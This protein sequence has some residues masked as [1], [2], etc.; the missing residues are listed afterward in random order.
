LHRR[1]ASEEALLAQAS[2]FQ[3]VSEAIEKGRQLVS[4]DLVVV[5]LI[6]LQEGPAQL[7]LLV[8]PCVFELAPGAGGIQA[9]GTPRHDNTATPAKS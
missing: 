4:I 2:L 3:S 9:S 1:D 6:E 8:L 5:V 7:E